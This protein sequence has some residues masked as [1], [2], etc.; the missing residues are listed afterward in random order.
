M[1]ADGRL[2][3][4]SPMA[5]CCISISRRR[6][7][8]GRGRL[9]NTP[10]RALTWPVTEELCH[11]VI[12]K[13]STVWLMPLPLL[14]KNKEV[15][16]FRPVSPHSPLAISSACL[17]VAVTPVL[18]QLINAALQRWHRVVQAGHVTSRG[19]ERVEARRRSAGVADPAV[20]IDGRLKVVEC[21]DVSRLALLRFLVRDLV[22]LR[23]LLLLKSFLF[24]DMLLIGANVL[25]PLAVLD[26]AILLLVNKASMVRFE[27]CHIRFCLYWQ[28]PPGLVVASVQ[29]VLQ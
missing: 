26:G 8:E 1:Q 21:L 12:W 9:Q 20:V 23:M 13:E 29:G 7:H 22:P 16:H 17:F 3:G 5:R 25:P 15:D 2:L 6:N 10:A 28:T 11:P 14:A 24:A 27:R 4:W 18:V 19:P